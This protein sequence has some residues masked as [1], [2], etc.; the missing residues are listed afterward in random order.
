LAVLVR[1]SFEQQFKV[2]AQK[3]YRWCTSY[4]PED[5]ALMGEEKVTREI[6][7][8]TKEV[9]ILVDTYSADAGDVK[10]QR[11]V[12]LYPDKLWWTSTHLSGPNRYSQFLYQIVPEN[13]A[14]CDLI[15]VGLHLEYSLKDASQREIERISNRRRK[16]D[17]EVWKKLASKMEEEI[18]L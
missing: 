11:L 9:V 6:Q 13:E 4:T 15:F 10:K 8:V 17:S 2:P 5:P 16:I 7:P 12:C 3:A 1:Y 14:S 18:Q